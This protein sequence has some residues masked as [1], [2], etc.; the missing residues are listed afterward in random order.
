[1][2]E[3]K[4]DANLYQ[5]VFYSSE[6]YL[7]DENGT[8]T[9]NEVVRFC[10]ENNCKAELYDESGFRNGWVHADGNYFLV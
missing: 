6:K 8:Y 1:M 4:L 2:H 7:D 5:V 9:L 10:K 3:E